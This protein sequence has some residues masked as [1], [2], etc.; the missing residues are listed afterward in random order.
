MW[1]SRVLK[2]LEFS[3]EFPIPIP[4]GRRGLYLSNR[5]Q[6]PAR[7]HP[8]PSQADGPCKDLEKA[9]REIPL[10]LTLPLRPRDKGRLRATQ[11]WEQKEENLQ[12]HRLYPQCLQLTLE[13][14][15]DPSLGPWDP[16]LSEAQP[17]LVQPEGRNGCLLPVKQSV[18]KTALLRG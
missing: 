16:I 10:G 18:W 4:L 8:S 7:L 13:K 9:P 5:S 17:G 12:R 3:E 2:I 1:L 14:R 15:T 6:R 11:A